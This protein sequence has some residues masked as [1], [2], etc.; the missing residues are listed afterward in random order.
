MPWAVLSQVATIFELNSGPR[1]QF[2]SS[3]KKDA[4][5]FPYIRKNISQTIDSVNNCKKP[6]KRELKVKKKGFEESGVLVKLQAHQSCQ[7]YVSG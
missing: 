2:K 3:E 5:S 1:I 4:I 7:L 6:R